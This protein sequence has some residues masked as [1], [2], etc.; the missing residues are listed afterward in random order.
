[1]K[2]HNTIIRQAGFRV[3]W[4]AYQC[5]F[6]TKTCKFLIHI[7]SKIFPTLGTFSR[8]STNRCVKEF[9]THFK[10]R[11]PK[12]LGA[13][14]PF[15]EILD[16]LVDLLIVVSI[17]SSVQT[18]QTWQHRD[19]KMGGTSCFVTIS[20]HILLF[21]RLFFE[22]KSSPI[23]NISHFYKPKI[24]MVFFCNDLSRLQTQNT[25][26]SQRLLLPFE[27]PMVFWWQRKLHSR[28]SLFGFTFRKQLSRPTIWQ[29]SRWCFLLSQ[30]CV[31][32]VE[33]VA[34]KK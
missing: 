19:L 14:F 5:D 15:W 23:S 25:I 2:S 32:G 33:Q 20:I 1:M 9:L 31:H 30:V 28:P 8:P 26:R 21:Q 22:Y 3:R 11:R 10:V 29:Q 34:R 16:V 6:F 24:S 12:F 7:Y 13:Y 4:K 18:G 17:S 27:G